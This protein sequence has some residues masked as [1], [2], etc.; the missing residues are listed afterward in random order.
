MDRLHLPEFVFDSKLSRSDL[1]WFI[2]NNRRID[3]S[4]LILTNPF[5]ESAFRVFKSSKKR[6]FMSF[7]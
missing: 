3:A 6:P 7:I 4:H 5:L 1:S 2:I